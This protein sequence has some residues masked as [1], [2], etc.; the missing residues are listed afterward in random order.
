MPATESTLDSMGPRESVAEIVREILQT[1]KWN[2]ESLAIATG[3]TQPT[4]SH[5]LSGASIPRSRSLLKLLEIHYNS[6]CHRW[7]SQQFIPICAFAESY[8]QSLADDATESLRRMLVSTPLT[9]SAALSTPEAWIDLHIRPAELPRYVSAFTF[10]NHR[11]APSVFVVLVRKQLS[12][13]EQYRIGWEEVY[14]H[15]AHFPRALDGAT[16]PLPIS[17]SVIQ[18]HPTPAKHIKTKS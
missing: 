14:A 8:P 6:R 2:Q 12:A 15:V 17:A 13:T 18:H 4:I 7:S 10:A 3:V 16:K 5:W 1:E 9:R 11:T